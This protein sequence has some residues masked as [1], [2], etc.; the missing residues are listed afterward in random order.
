VAG[1]VFAGASQVTSPWITQAGSSGAFLGFSVVSV[2]GGGVAGGPATQATTPWIFVGSAFVSGSVYAS[3]AGSLSVGQLGT[4]SA[5]VQGS[6]FAS[7][8]G[9]LS[10]GQSGVWSTTVAGSVFAAALQVTSP[11]ITQPGSTGTFQGFTV[12]SIPAPVTVIG[13][14]TVAGSVFAGASQVTSPWIVRPDSTGDFVGFVVA[15]IVGGGSQVT[16]TSPVVMWAGQGDPGSSAL[17]TRSWVS[18]PLLRVSLEQGT[19]SAGADG[20]VLDF[21]QGAAIGWNIRSLSG[22]FKA[23]LV[24]IV[25][26][27]GVGAS[28]TSDATG[29]LLGVNLLRGSINLSGADGATLDGSDSTIRASVRSTAAFRPVM[30]GLTDP[31]GVHITAFSVT[32]ATSPWVISGSVTV[33]GSVYA[34][35]AG[36]LSVAQMGAW[37]ATVAG[38]VFAGASQVTSPWVSFP[39]STGAFQGFVVASVPAAVTVIGSTTVAGSVFASVAG[40]L[41][42]GQL[43]TWSATVAGSVFAG[44][45]QVTSPWVSFPGSTGAFQGFVVASVPA[46]VTVIGSATVAGSVFAGASQV[47][48]PWMV[49]PGSSGQFVGFVVASVVGVGGVTQATT[50]WLF[51]G[52]AFITPAASLAVAQMG[53]WSATVAGSVFAAALQVSSPWA[54]F[55]GSTGVFAGFVVASVPAAVTVIG[56][57][58]VAGSVF[59]SIAGSLSVAQLGVWSATVAGSVFAGASQVNSPWVVFPGSTGAFQGFMVASIPAAVTVI[60]SATVTGSVYAAMTGSLGV[61][62]LGVWSATVAGSVFA[63]ASQV[64]SP[65]VVFQGST[66]NFVG[67]VVASVMPLA[68]RVYESHEF[69]LPGSFNLLG[70]SS[71]NV[72]SLNHAGSCTCQRS[73]WTLVTADAQYLTLRN[74]STMPIMLRFDVRTG[75]RV[76]LDAGETM[77]F[78]SLRFS[79][80]YFLNYSATNLPIR[81]TWST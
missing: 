42:V 16:V 59:A 52:S 70:N 18:G 65:W 36:S 37:S 27:G 21:D 47:S 46:A 60:G 17:S 8:A 35:L 32:Q 15:S 68:T 7:V 50:P 22:G 11:W 26:S 51:T 13:S 77:T 25:S 34:S 10:V 20:K 61:A 3:I 41:S 79:A 49:Q 40:S 1:S 23:G 29:G 80:L 38:S 28:V 12:A 33:A 76:T 30:V 72:R 66:G 9:S 6:V 55:P 44:A 62:Q 5:T 45:S 71:M 75:D 43:G 56:S 4:W 14:A 64:S 73:A 53:T 57:T 67:F 69:G 48:S 58:T 54:V 2:V 81:M 78:D 31:A 24:S 63:G 74:V 19:L 39:G